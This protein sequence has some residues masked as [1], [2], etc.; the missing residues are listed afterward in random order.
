MGKELLECSETLARLTKTR[1]SNLI[2]FYDNPSL[3]E[4]LDVHSIDLLLDG[5]HRAYYRFLKHVLGKELQIIPFREFPLGGLVLT[6][7]RDVFS[8]LYHTPSRF[9]SLPEWVVG[10]VNFRKSIFV[11]LVEKN[12][13]F[14]SDNNGTCHEFTHVVIPDV[15]GLPTDFLDEVWETWIHEA[16]AVGINQRRSREWLVTELQ[17]PSI[18][19]PSAASLQ[20][21]GIFAHDRRFPHE[22]TAY[23]YCV[24]L[25]ESFGEAVGARLY[26]QWKEY[27]PLLPICHFT[28]D[29]F[30]WGKNSLVAAA[31][32]LGINMIAVENEMRTKLEL[33]PISK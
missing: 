3:L 23:Q 12:K 25:K 31:E 15:L 24:W 16:L 10:Y 6:K 11:R 14:N 7:S 17:S 4:E 13:L 32:D 20:K 27:S 28:Q 1:C 21:L 33:Q 30:R 18:K 5:Y 26:P 19:E 9:D 2:L 8:A 29:C 22:N